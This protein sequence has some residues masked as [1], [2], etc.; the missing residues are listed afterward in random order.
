MLWSIK[1]IQ[2]GEVITVQY[3]QDT[4]YF[5]EG[6]GCGSCNPEK[7]PVAPRRN[8][9]AGGSGS[10]EVGVSKKRT[11]RGGRRKP[12]KRLKLGDLEGESSLAVSQKG[13]G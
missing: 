10:G 7:P 1:N 6:C 3:T 2:E 5:P 8:I 13:S 12:G 11:R 4:S 9:E